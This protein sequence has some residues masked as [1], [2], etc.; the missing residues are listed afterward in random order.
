MKLTFKD[1]NF[2]HDYTR[3]AKHLWASKT[4]YREV[5]LT[6]KE[7]DSGIKV[8]FKG[9]YMHKHSKYEKEVFGKI[10]KVITKALEKHAESK[11]KD[12]EKAQKIKD[13]IVDHIDGK[14]VHNHKIEDVKVKVLT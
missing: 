1:H 7:K 2:G 5:E 14:K 6:A 13:Y 8:E 12:S 10:E 9:L 4:Y 3:E 11:K